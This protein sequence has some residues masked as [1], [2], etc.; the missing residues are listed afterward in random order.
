MYQLAQKP[1]IVPEPTVWNHIFDKLLDMCTYLS[2]QG[3]VRDQG[4]PGCQRL[5]VAPNAH[6]A[7]ST[8]KAAAVLRSLDGTHKRERQPIFMPDGF[9]D[10]MWGQRHRYEAAPQ[11]W[12]NVHLS[13]AA[14]QERKVTRRKPVG[15]FDGSVLVRWSA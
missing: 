1:D 4:Q 6:A 3:Y 14:S 9:K 5:G 12:T 11:T 7:V 2:H 8:S 13:G 15:T 10:M